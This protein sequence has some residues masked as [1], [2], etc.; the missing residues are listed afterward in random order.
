MANDLSPAGFEERDHTA[1]WSLHVWAPD[2]AGLLE[3]A[4]KGMA[5]LSG[6]KTAGGERITR[7]LKVESTDAEGLL[8]NFLTELLHIFDQENLFFDK[9]TLSV[10]ENTLQAAME[11]FPV[12]ER[13]KEIKAVT[14]H[15][16]VIEKKA[17]GLEAD[18][19]FDV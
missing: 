8:V 4:A 11:G 9:F 15:N 7:S 18:I 5:D 12:L 16:L 19:V 14:Y 6:V 17:K 1:D 13:K 2:F 3:Q 10:S